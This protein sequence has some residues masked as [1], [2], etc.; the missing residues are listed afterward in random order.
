MAAHNLDH[1]W[2]WLGLLAGGSVLYVSPSLTPS[3]LLAM[4]KKDPR[5]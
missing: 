1:L 3:L 4:D 5:R 2:M